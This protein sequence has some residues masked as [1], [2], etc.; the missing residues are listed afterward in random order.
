MRLAHPA[1]ASA[2]L[3]AALLGVVTLSGCATVVRGGHQDFRVETSPPGAS[4][5]TTLRAR[6][7]TALGCAPTPCSVRVP[8]RSTFVAA[9]ELD[10]HQPVR[11][12]VRPASSADGALLGLAGGQALGLG[13]TATSVAATSGTTVG[14]FAGAAVASLPSFAAALGLAGLLSGPFIFVDSSTGALG[15]VF[16]SGL[17]IQLATQAEASKPV[18]IVDP[19]AVLRAEVDRRA[20]LVGN[21][22]EPSPE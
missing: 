16:P 2:I 7:G 9:V 1:S 18:L 22:A 5:A 14:S 19:D 17:S 12:A 8:R 20:G 11:V 21:P 13:V 6:D 15:S 10:G 4:V 3:A